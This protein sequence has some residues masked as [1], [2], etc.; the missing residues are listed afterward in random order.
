MRSIGL[1]S[2]PGLEPNGRDTPRFDE[3]QALRADQPGEQA[4]RN[5]QAPDQLPQ[6]CA[7]VTLAGSTFTPGPMVEVMAMRSI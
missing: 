7:P 6:P 2:A 1:S 5:P 4:A 3:A